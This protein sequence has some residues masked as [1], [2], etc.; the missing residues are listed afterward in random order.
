[1]LKKIESLEQERFRG[2]AW[3][4]ESV[5]SGDTSQIEPTSNRMKFGRLYQFNYYDPKT[6]DQMAYWNT[7]PV[8]IKV[9]QYN[10]LHEGTL[11]VCVNLNFFPD[12]VK[13]QFIDVYWDRYSGLYDANTATPKSPVEQKQAQFDSASFFQIFKPFGIGFTT[14]RYINNRITKM[15]VFSNEMDTWA[16][17][18]LIK[19]PSF[20]KIGV[21][22]RDKLFA[23]YINKTK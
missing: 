6:R 18:M 3:V 22:T 10:S 13:R 2:N 12:N 20:S 21:S 23:E 14:R 4:N 7:N 19:Y 5:K 9:G 8:V 1:M 11:D 17:A 15:K 16:Q